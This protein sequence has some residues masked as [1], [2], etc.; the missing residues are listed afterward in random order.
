MNIDLK[1]KSYQHRKDKNKTS[2][3]RE[4]WHVNEVHPESVKTTEK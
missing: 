2:H 3:K 4:R 1:L